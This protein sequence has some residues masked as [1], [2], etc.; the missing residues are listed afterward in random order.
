MKKKTLSLLMLLLF[1]STSIIPASASY[2]VTSNNEIAGISIPLDSQHME[3]FAHNMTAI[4]ESAKG[5]SILL[6]SPSERINELLL[7]IPLADAEEKELINTE[8]ETYGVYEYTV[9]NSDNAASPCSI[10]PDNG[11]VTL[12]T[13]SIYYQTWESSWTI[14]CG[15]TW[16]NDSW[17][18]GSGNTGILNP[19]NEV[20][21]NDA[22]G[23]GFTNTSGAYEN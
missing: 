16:N 13:P 15:G 5:N 17:K 1:M 19:T 3:E 11:D 23:V 10:S 4:Y 20:G 8:L 9:F 18:V 2:A 22:F 7:R 14:T 6:E 21:G 12:S